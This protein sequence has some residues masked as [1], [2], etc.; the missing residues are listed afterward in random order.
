MTAPIDI[1]LVDDK[2]ENLMVLESILEGPAYRLTRAQ[3]AQEALM[4]LITTD[5]AL[6]VLDIRMPDTSGLEL[7]Q[8]IKGRKRTRDIPIIF[9]TAPER[10]TT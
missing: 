4:A 6:I 5:F 10:S 2:P 3:S 7:A 9:L 8:I 1:L